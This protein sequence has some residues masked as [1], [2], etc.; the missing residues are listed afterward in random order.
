MKILNVLKR[1]A[2]TAYARHVLRDPQLLEAQRWFKDKGDQTLRLN[3]DLDT[4]SVVFDIGGYQGDYAAAIHEKYACRVYLFEPVR[5]YYEECQKRFKENGAI[6]CFNFG[7]SNSNESVEIDV[8]ENASSTHFSKMENKKE[9]VFLTSILDFIRQSNI[10]KIDLMKINIEG[11][12]FDVLPALIGSGLIGVVGNVQIQF[13]NFIDDAERKRNAI[14]KDLALTHVEEW[15]YKF[16]WESWR[17][18]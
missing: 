9:L 10:K 4:N 3:Y 12:E 1:K 13:H 8:S 18:K 14:R 7:L 11:G 6:Q 16:V 17:L 5:A 2:K 15:N